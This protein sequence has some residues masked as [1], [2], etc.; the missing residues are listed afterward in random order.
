MQIIEN[1]ANKWAPEQQIK[2]SIK[3]IWHQLS[4]REIEAIEE[5]RDVFFLAVKKKH[6][7]PRAEAELVLRGLKQKLTE[8]A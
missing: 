6:G 2:N 4:E 3:H 8:M 5:Q 1:G 7:L